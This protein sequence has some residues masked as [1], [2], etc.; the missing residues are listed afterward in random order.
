MIHGRCTG[1]KAVKRYE[2]ARP[3]GRGPRAAAAARPGA[4]SPWTLQR[5]VAWVAHPC[6]QRRRWRVDARRGAEPGCWRSAPAPVGGA[7]C[8]SSLL[9]VAT[10]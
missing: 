7:Q 9:T 1:C 3:A 10:P 6:G 8:A 4:C 5:A 2:P